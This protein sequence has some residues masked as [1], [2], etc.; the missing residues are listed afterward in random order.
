MESAAQSSPAEACPGGKEDAQIQIVLKQS[1]ELLWSILD[2]SPSSMLIVDAEG[3]CVKQ[4]QACLR[5]LGPLDA[6]CDNKYNILTDQAIADQGFTP[7]V[8][9]VFEKGDTARFTL[10]LTLYSS[11]DPSESI[12][13]SRRLL[14]VTVFPVKDSQGRTMSAVVQHLDVTKINQAQRRL[15]RSE[16]TYRTLVENADAAIMIID[17]TGRYVFLNLQGSRWVGEQ[18]GDYVGK[19]IFDHFPPEHANKKLSLIKSVIQ[20][21]KS[22]VVETEAPF[23]DTVRWMRMSILP[24]PAQGMPCR[25]AMLICTDLTQKRQAQKAIEQYVERL[26]VLR[27]M[28]NSILEA[29]SLVEIANTGL[30]HLRRLIP[31]VR[32]SLFEIDWQSGTLKALAVRTDRPT[33]IDKGFERPAPFFPDFT[34]FEQGRPRMV[35]DVRKVQNPVEFERLLLAEGICSY[36][37]VPLITHGELV[38][39]MNVAS[40]QAGVFTQ[41]HLDIAQ[42]LG[43]PLAIAI[44][45]Q[46]AS[47]AQQRSQEQLRA[48]TDMLQAIVQASPIAINALDLEGRVK[49]WSPAAERIFGWKQEEV[50]GKPLAELM[51]GDRAQFEDI[52]SSVK[53]GKSTQGIQAKRRRKDGTVVDVHVSVAPLRDASGKT[54]GATGLVADITDQVKAQQELQRERDFARNMVATA[55]SMVVV[56]DDVGKIVLI[57]PFAQR[58]T[59]YTEE[60]VLGKLGTDI[61]VPTDQRHSAHKGFFK[62]MDGPQTHTPTERRVLCKDGR[63]MLIRWYIAILHDSAS[64]PT[65][66]L[67]TGY[68]ITEIRCREEQ[69]R[70]VQKMEAIGRLAG[71]VAHDFNNQLTIIKGYSELL[72][73]EISADDKLR[74]PINEILVAATRSADLTRQ[75]LAFSRQQATHAQVINVNHTLRQAHSLLAHV[76]GEDVTLVLDCDEG[77]WATQVDAAQL[78]HVIM[79]LAVNA[80]DA[81]PGGGTFTIR[82]VNFVP[83]MAFSNNHATPKHDQYVLMTVSDTGCGIDDDTRKRIFEPFFTTKPVGKGTGLGLSIVYGFV[84]Q[85]GGHIDVQSQPGKGTTFLIYLPRIVASD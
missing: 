24:L 73:Q 56:L 43:R 52:F 47:D 55:Q 10:Q 45:N 51:A 37:R 34:V 38:A 17:E 50:L 23:G 40:D 14:D 70:Q 41:Q 5:L 76:M 48:T 58:L 28:N 67:L 26:T 69:M 65:G 66:M 7:Q 16:L 83:D 46:K 25:T 74:G 1:Q 39:L 49:I 53:E 57:N 75:L 42:E 15:R 19:T 68:D 82:T 44:L 85:S 79:N 21:Q 77:L 81:M 12:L 6:A 22:S 2:Q 18:G 36:L 13:S 64:R 72:L 54:I 29:R 4:N 80:K 35:E 20:S 78:E 59:G 61:F 30:D 62:V 27:E 32:A 31:C 71:G 9:A 84:Q 60:E 8:R 11:T 33:A 3:N 63:E